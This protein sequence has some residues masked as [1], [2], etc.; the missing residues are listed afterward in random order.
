M[1]VSHYDVFQ[2]STHKQ[3]VFSSWAEVA[4][5]YTDKCWFLLQTCVARVRNSKC[6]LWE[7]L[8]CAVWDLTGF[9]VLIRYIGMQN[10]QKRSTPIRL[11]F[12]HHLP[13]HHVAKSV[14]TALFCSYSRN[15]GKTAANP[16]VVALLATVCFYWLSS[17]LLLLLKHFMLSLACSITMPLYVPELSQ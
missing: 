3:L 8:H 1:I 11:T 14:I 16:T 5:A 13:G 12:Y 15:S 9:F 2:T 7:L 6:I 10:C 17:K 4:F